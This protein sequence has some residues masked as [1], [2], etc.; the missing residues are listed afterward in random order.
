MS[1]GSSRRRRGLHS[2]NVWMNQAREGSPWISGWGR[3]PEELVVKTV[4]RSTQGTW[5]VT[6]VSPGKG[7]R[8]GTSEC[9]TATV[10]CWTVVSPGPDAVRRRPGA[11]SDH[12]TAES[13][14]QLTFFARRMLVQCPEGSA[15]CRP[16]FFPSPHPRTFFSFGGCKSPQ[17]QKADRLG[18]SHPLAR[19]QEVGA[20][21]TRTVVAVP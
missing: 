12:G 3:A 16:A 1:F 8:L 15:L 13:H 11:P 14:G 2:W 6:L 7:L 20:F 5:Y 19:C 10:S 18:C 17:L 9:D 21:Q 4:L